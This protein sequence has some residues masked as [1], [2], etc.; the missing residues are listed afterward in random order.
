MN[1]DFYDF[2]PR[3]SPSNIIEDLDVLTPQRAYAG[4]G[5]RKTPSDVL[6]DMEAFAYIAAKHNWMLR[7]GYAEGADITFERGC[8]NGQGKKEIFLPWPGFRYNIFSEYLRPTKEA[9]EL[10]AKVHP[11][12][13]K[14]SHTAK[15]LVARNMHQILGYDLKSPVQ[16][17]V[18][19]TPNGQET[20]KQ[21][22]TKSGGTGSAI[23]LADECGIPVYNLFNKDRYLDAVEFLLLHRN[24]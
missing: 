2:G 14:L 8:D 7:S 5:S 24:G 9:H 1:N 18:C 20:M 21:Y 17:V 19:Y 23:A 22:N 4:I 3:S 16:F 13:K 10:A 11:A 15:S 12:Y 6:K